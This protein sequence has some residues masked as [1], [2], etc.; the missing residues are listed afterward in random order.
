M[1]FLRGS[2]QIDSDEEGYIDSDEEE[3]ELGDLSGSIGYLR[4]APNYTDEQ[5]SHIL[6]RLFVA[7]GKK[8]AHPQDMVSMERVNTKPAGSNKRQKESDSSPSKMEE[9][10]DSPVGEGKKKLSNLAN[11]QQC[12]EKLKSGKPLSDSFLSM[13]QKVLDKL[14]LQFIYE[15]GIP[16]LVEKIFEE[17]TASKTRDLLVS[18]FQ[19]TSAGLGNL[20][21]TKNLYNSSSSSDKGPEKKAEKALFESCTCL[22]RTFEP[23]AKDIDHFLIDSIYELLSPS[24]RSSEQEESIYKIPNPISEVNEQVLTEKKVRDLLE[25]GCNDDLKWKLES[26]LFMF[27]CQCIFNIVSKTIPPKQSS[28]QTVLDFGL[29][30]SRKLRDVE[31]TNKKKTSSPVNEVEDMGLLDIGTSA[32]LALLQATMVLVT[33]KVE[34]FQTQLASRKPNEN[35]A[36]FFKVMNN[37]VGECEGQLQKFQTE[38]KRLEYIVQKKTKTWRE[39]PSGFPSPKSEEENHEEL[40][41]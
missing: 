31:S 41:I 2:A 7:Q 23:V 13:L 29:F 26:V 12:V 24:S 11:P 9:S 14:P 32:S 8:R 3:E 28:I 18:C 30:L 15:T 16:V 25:K 35:E 27:Q 33:K 39:H 1:W 37:F 21:D 36:K 19:S 10:E 40:D 20:L 4:D 22:L 34:S 6:G 38:L 17:N 5:F